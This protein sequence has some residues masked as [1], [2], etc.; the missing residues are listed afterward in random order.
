MLRDLR[1]RVHGSRDKGRRATESRE[2]TGGFGDDRRGWTTE[3]VKIPPMHVKGPPVPIGV[4]MKAKV[5][6]GRD[7]Y[8]RVFTLKDASKLAA[9]IRFRQSRENKRSVGDAL[10][11]RNV[12]F[13]AWRCL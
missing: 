1:R 3:Y 4:P 9:S 8:F 7:H 10:R 11:S 13:R 2:T 6:Q 12:D 5:A